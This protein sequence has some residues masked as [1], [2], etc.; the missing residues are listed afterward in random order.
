MDDFGNCSDRCRTDISDC[1]PDSVFKK[2]EK[3]FKGVEV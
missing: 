3:H 2:N 1:F